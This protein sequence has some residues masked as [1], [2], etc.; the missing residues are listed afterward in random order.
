MVGGFDSTRLNPFKILDSHISGSEVKRTESLISPPIHGIFTL[1]TELD[2]L[3]ARQLY[4]QHSDVSR[5]Q[6][7]Y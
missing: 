2:F 1:P 3:V 4:D 7:A 5:P 6:I